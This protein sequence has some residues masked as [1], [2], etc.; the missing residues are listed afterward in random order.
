MKY[1]NNQRKAQIFSL[2]VFFTMLPVIILLGAGLQYMHLAQEG[3]KN[4]ME[5]NQLEMLVETFSNNVVSQIDE[6]NAPNGGDCSHFKTLLQDSEYLLKGHT[7][8]EYY[9]HVTVKEDTGTE[10]CG[11]SYELWS[12]GLNPLFGANAPTLIRDTT[13]SEIRFIIQRDANG[14][15]IPGKIAV[16]T[17]SVWENVS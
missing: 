14:V 13:A 7:D 4:F 11:S 3:S 17:F 12:N 6:T 1:H 9:Y 5:T 15:P 10:I 8:N 2:D 16:L